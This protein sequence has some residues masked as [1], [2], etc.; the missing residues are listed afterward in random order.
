MTALP[1]GTPAAELLRLTADGREAD[2]GLANHAAGCPHCTA[3]LAALDADWS[4][5]REAA[6]ERPRTPPGLADRAL[7]A[8]SGVR[9][10]PGSYHDIADGVRVADRVVVLIARR[11]AADA[12]DGL[13]SVRDVHT[14][15]NKVHIGLAVRW[16]VAADTLAERVRTAVLAALANQVGP[17]VSAVDVQVN[18]VLPPPFG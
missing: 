12:L 1:C 17:V 3:E 10:A 2:P 11:A 16:G 6:R 18:D 7:G 8:L 13:G 14:G 5:V 9:A 15:Q 4:G